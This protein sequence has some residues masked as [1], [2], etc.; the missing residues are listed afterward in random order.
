MLRAEVELTPGDSHRGRQR[1][2][3]TRSCAQTLLAKAFEHGS[4][5][6]A[7]RHASAC[8]TVAVQPAFTNLALH[9]VTSVGNVVLVPPSHER[10]HAYP[11]LRP[12][13]QSQSVVFSAS[14][15][16]PSGFV[17]VSP[18]LAVVVLG[19]HVP[20]GGPPSSAAHTN[21]C[22]QRLLAGQ[23]PALCMQS[24]QQVPLWQLDPRSQSLLPRQRATHRPL[25]QLAVPHWIDEVHFIEQNPTSPPKTKQESEEPQGFDASHFAPSGVALGATVVAASD[26]A[27]T[28]GSVGGVA[29]FAGVATADSAGTTSVEQAALVSANG[30]ARRNSEASVMRRMQRETATCVPAFKS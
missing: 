20:G 29:S 7:A 28:W 1:Q 24:G 17:D 5:P 11:P 6:T 26:S 18:E 14:D 30:E 13:A 12:A 2:L 16:A 3:G 4:S 9:F 22:K 25:S 19:L 21:P 27:G 23:T 8:A 10:L 15:S